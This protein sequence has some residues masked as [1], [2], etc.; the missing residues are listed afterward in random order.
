MR[1][2]AHT[3][4]RE[5]SMTETEA[6][7]PAFVRSVDGIELPAAGRWRID[8]GH[9]EV[10]FIGRHLVFTKVRGRFLAVDGYVD[11]ALDPN[12]SVVDVTID[13]ASV[14]SGDA[15]RDVHLRSGDLFDV[16]RFPTATFRGGPRGWTGRRGKLVGDLRIKEV[17][18]T[19]EL[20]VTYLGA[21]ADPWG[22]QRAIY[23]AW[24]MIDREA[25][26]LDWNM[27]MAGGGLLVSKEIR[28]E[29]ELET[30]LEH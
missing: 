16:D 12:D 27:P 22:G 6:P 1:A 21:V 13:M 30:V 8:P 14:D 28:L 24:T 15:T 25:W 11:I 23:S 17:T 18:R 3:L 10:G 5:R 9:T 4:E 29:L 7:V 26:G 2:Y 20:D 19:V